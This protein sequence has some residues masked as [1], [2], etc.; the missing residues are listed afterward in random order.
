M[1]ALIGDILLVLALILAFLQSTLPLYGYYI[2]SPRLLAT[3]RPATFLQCLLLLSALMT[4][5]AA[6][7]Y[8]D[9]SILYVAHHSHPQLPFIYQLTASWG[10]HEGSILLWITLSSIWSA[11]FA[12]TSYNRSMMAISIS[13]MGYLNAALILFLLSTCNPFLQTTDILSGNDLNPLLQD[14]G[15]VMHPPILYAGYA[16]FSIIFAMTLA[17]LICNQLNKEWAKVTQCFALA[18]WSFLSLGILLG[19]WWSYHVLGWGGF[20]FWDPV[21]N[22]SL[23]PWLTGLALI[24]ILLLVGRKENIKGWAVFLALLSFCLSLLGTFLVRSGLLISVHTFTSDPKRGLYLLLLF[25]I[26]SLVTL[27]IYFIKHPKIQKKQIYTPTLLSR[28]FSLLFN[29]TILMIGMFTILL[30]TLYPLILESLHIATISV[31]APYF[32][33]V[34]A[35]LTFLLIIGMGL[36]SISRWQAPT[37]THTWPT[38]RHQLLLGIT[39]ACIINLLSPMH[40]T[41]INFLLLWL[42]IAVLLG[43][44]NRWRLFPAMFFSHLGFIVLLLGIVLSNALSQTN[45]IRMHAGETTSLGPY[46]FLFKK[47]KNLHSS[48]YDAIQASFEIQKKGKIITYLYPEKRLYTANHAVL[49]KADIQ[50][51]LF[52]D[53]YIAL[54]EPLP[55]EDWSI[56]IYY[57]PFISWIWMGGLLMIAG[58]VIAMVKRLCR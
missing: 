20:W 58:S 56:R 3:A 46:Q 2:N 31:G 25:G 38:I 28:E 48:N 27:A 8:Q 9:F 4:L 44:S 35:P 52:R 13:I 43:L 1:I 54:G 23:L 16:G 10:G 26:V 12:L 51:G 34:M 32:N 55:N 17:A 49:G 30:G 14:P 45:D 29:N 24:H 41:L 36:A 15:F 57:K 5:S 37:I 11:V 40:L 7:I 47:T 18:A 42:C 21:E 33:S 22:I 50:T 19:S 6:F 53:L 39:L